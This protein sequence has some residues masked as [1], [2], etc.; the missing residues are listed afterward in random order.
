[1]KLGADRIRQI[2]LSLRNFSRLDESAIKSVD[3]H[4]GID[5]TLLILQHRL[6]QHDAARPPIQIVKTYGDL[7]LVECYASQL[8]QV[9]VNLLSNAID[10]LEDQPHQ[11]HLVAPA[12]QIKTNRVNEDWVAIH[13]ADNGPGIPEHFRDRVFD[14]F[15]TT[16]AIG[17]GTGLGLSISQQIIIDRHQGRMRCHS[18][19]GQ[20]TEFIIELPVGQSAVT[21]QPAA[22]LHSVA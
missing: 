5:S 19:P 15:F 12:I 13:I 7:P 2:V 3:L 22:A 4:G 16:K 21:P 14:A 17:K 1:M 11:D 9:F 18:A 20:G 10:A 6:K 8:N